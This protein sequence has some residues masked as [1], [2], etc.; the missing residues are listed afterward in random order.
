MHRFSSERADRFTGEQ[1]DSVQKPR[2]ID[3][4]FSPARVYVRRF[5]AE[6]VFFFPLRRFCV[7]SLCQVED[8]CLFLTRGKS[9]KF[10]RHLLSGKYG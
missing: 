10:V 5:K 9:G 7:F 6:H 3:S 1:I 4:S 8:F 2:R